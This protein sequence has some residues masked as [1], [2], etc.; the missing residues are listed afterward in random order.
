M[1]TPLS[2]RF[3]VTVSVYSVLPEVIWYASTSTLSTM[4]T[5]PMPGM[6]VKEKM[7]FGVDVFHV[8]F[9]FLIVVSR[10]SAAPDIA[11]SS[12]VMAVFSSALAFCASRY[13]L[14]T[15]YCTVL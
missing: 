5:T 9:I 1:V 4:T 14:N 3:I 12:A 10:A 11:C 15:A 2:I 7:P 6:A 8:V 13:D